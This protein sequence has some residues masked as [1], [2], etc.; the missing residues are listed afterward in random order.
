MPFRDYRF[1]AADLKIMSQAYDAAVAK[2]A[3]E[4][5]NPGTSKLAAL[6]VNLLR[7]GERDPV[8]LCDRAVMQL[9]KKR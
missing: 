7:E 5:T 1:D 4:N 6:I 2:L 3:L 8:K 9:R